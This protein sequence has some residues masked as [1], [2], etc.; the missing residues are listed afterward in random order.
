MIYREIAESEIEALRGKM[1]SYM[2]ARRYQHTLAVENMAARLA[3]L[4]CPDKKNKL[5]AAALLH[6][7]TKELS[8]Q[9]HIEICR[10]H[11]EALLPEELYAPKTLHAKTA[12]VLIPERFPEFSDI[13]I[14]SA[15]RF[16]TTGCAYMTLF[17]KIIYL[18]DYIDCTRTH[19]DCVRLRNMFWDACPAEMSEEQRS[20]HLD[21]VLLEAIGTTVNSLIESKKVISCD[22]ISARNSLILNLNNSNKE[23]VKK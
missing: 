3:D 12:A 15:V 20:E 2:S 10:E 23:T 8:E 6:D 4:Y 19:E 11:G 1:V 14:I 5:R 13:E 22:T 16:H 21:R 9:E 17:E 7:M 18:S